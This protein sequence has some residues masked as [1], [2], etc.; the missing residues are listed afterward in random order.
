M[1]IPP[2]CAGRYSFDGVHILGAKTGQTAG[3]LMRQLVENGWTQ[4][5]TIACAERGLRTAEFLLGAAQLN[6]VIRSI[7]GGL[8]KC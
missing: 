7:N 2:D 1:H 8:D 5:W 4:V 6:L 3:Q